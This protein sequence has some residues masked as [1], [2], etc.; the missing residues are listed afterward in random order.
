MND[1]LYVALSFVFVFII[2]GLST[3]LQTKRVLDDEGARK[4]VH[5]GVAHWWFFVLLF[6]HWLY[7]VIAPVAFI[8][9]NYL[10]YRQNIFKAME[11]GGKGNLGTVYFPISLLLLVLF[12]FFI[13]ENKAYQFIGAIA[14]LTLGYGDGLAAV[15]GKRFGKT[16]WIQGKSLEGSLVMFAATAVVTTFVIF[17][18]QPPIANPGFMILI[19]PLVATLIEMFTPKGL[20]N[21]SVP[22]GV[23]LLVYSLM[24]LGIFG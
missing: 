8:I 5:I 22:L 6:D 16:K 3:L 10:S 19:V 24:T 15:I 9:L 2:I 21:L 23:T 1:L 12:T 18:Y 20:D 11:R 4:F 7:A 14:M 13:G 17:T